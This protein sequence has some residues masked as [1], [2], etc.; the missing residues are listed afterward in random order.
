MKIDK[1][2]KLVGSFHNNKK[3]FHTNK[4]PESDTRLWAITN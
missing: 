3:I 2:E 4:G 1:C